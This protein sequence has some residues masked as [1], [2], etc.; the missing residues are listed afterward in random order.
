MTDNYV[1]PQLHVDNDEPTITLSDIWK[2][3]WGY[4][5]WY[6][7]C[8]IVCLAGA[9]FYLYRTPDKYLRTAKVIIDESE[10]DATMRSLG[11]ITGSAVRM[12]SNATVANEME[13]LASPDLM[14]MVVE[15]LA[16]ETRY[17]EQQLFRTVELYDTTP[18]EMRLAGDNPQSGFS[19]LQ[20]G[21]GNGKVVLTDFIVGG[22]EVEGKV[23]CALGDTVRTPAGV[24]ILYPTSKVNDL[25]NPIRISRSNSMAI[26]K[27]YC[28]E[29][30][31]SL[32]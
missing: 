18:V 23:E 26:A 13:A 20:N 9:A 4:K 16:L 19:F 7:A 29:L 11:A 12:R 14:Q 28:S 10:Q 21:K 30:S 15:R 32:S 27:H 6:V 17:V 8:V 1:N 3:I 31:V 22:E 24:L 2:M 5:W 25:V